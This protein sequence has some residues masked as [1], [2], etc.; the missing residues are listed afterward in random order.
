MHCWSWSIADRIWSYN[1]RC[2]TLQKCETN[3]S[4]C[5]NVMPNTHRRHWRDS[6]VEL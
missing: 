5:T 6:T 2:F 4:A 3:K 1:E